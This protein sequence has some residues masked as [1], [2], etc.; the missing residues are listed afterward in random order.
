MQPGSLLGIWQQNALRL[1]MFHDPRCGFVPGALS[2]LGRQGSPWIM[3]AGAARVVH[4]RYSSPEKTRGG[5]GR[6]GSELT[7][8]FL[9]RNSGFS[10]SI[11]VAAD[12]GA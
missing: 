6:A 8:H 2:F 11:F 4:G 10:D 7:L 12:R 9:C 3:F 1:F 5:P